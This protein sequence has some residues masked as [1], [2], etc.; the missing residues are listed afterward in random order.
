MGSGK[1]REARQFAEGL[2]GTL[3]D[4]P[5]KRGP[6]TG[7]RRLDPGPQTLIKRHRYRSI[8]VERN[9]ALKADGAPRTVDFAAGGTDTPVAPASA[10]KTLLDLVRQA[11]MRDDDRPAAL[12]TPRI[13]FHRDT[14]WSR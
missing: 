3:E 5:F 1:I 4:K 13:P 9:A 6:G 7:D 14:S 11:G 2:A 12:D 10:L 8:P